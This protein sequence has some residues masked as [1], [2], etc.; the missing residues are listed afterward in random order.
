MRKLAIKGVSSGGLSPVFYHQWD[1]P[2]KRGAVWIPGQ[3]HR[4]SGPVVYRQNGF[5]VCD[6]ERFR[7]WKSWLKRK[8]KGYVCEWRGEHDVGA[9]A[10]A[11]REC[12]LL[13]PWDGKSAVS[14][15]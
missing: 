8:V 6:S 11:V 13:R 5:H 7:R 14:F 3:W 2:K 1:L 10:L 9:N 12:R 15:E 4:V